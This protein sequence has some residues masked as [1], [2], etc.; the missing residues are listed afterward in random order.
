M[1]LALSGLTNDIQDTQE[2]YKNE[3]N[4]KYDLFDKNAVR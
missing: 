1:V 2:S 4:V 3:G